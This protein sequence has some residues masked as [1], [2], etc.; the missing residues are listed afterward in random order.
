MNESM[1]QLLSIFG[2][3]IK[4]NQFITFAYSPLDDQWYFLDMK[5][6]GCYDSVETITSPKEAYF[7]MIEE[8]WYYWLEKNRLLNGDLS[9]EKNVSALAPEIRAVLD[10]FLDPYITA[11]KPYL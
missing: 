7:H 3:I 4:A 2:E 11:A 6:N 1:N 5:S 9:L 8:C 10:H